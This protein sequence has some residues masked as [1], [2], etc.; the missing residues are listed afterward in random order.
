[1]RR[2]HLLPLLLLAVTL[3]AVGGML[4][5]GG[6]S[7]RSP[8]EP[9]PGGQQLTVEVLDSSF[10]PKSLQINPGDTVVWV[11]HGSMFNHTV[12]D[13]G[14]AFDSGFQFKTPNATFQHTFGTDAA[15]QT[16]NY[17]C[18]T[19]AALGMKGSIRVGSN[20]PQPGP[21]Y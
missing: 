15:G 8:T 3:I 17:Q 12:T 11:L 2:R 1:M 4:A 10:S 5:C 14:G 20:A 9:M 13:T 18:T 16:F 6:S 19:H 21:G 7:Y